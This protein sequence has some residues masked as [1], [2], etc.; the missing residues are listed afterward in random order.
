MQ[1]HG[2][3]MALLSLLNILSSCRRVG[4][5]EIRFEGKESFRHTR[6]QE[7]EN[8]VSV[9]VFFF[10]TPRRGGFSSRNTTK[11]PLF[12]NGFDVKEMFLELG[13]E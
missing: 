10:F 2:A 4:N 13:G 9:S 8:Q 6:R 1:S 12:R 11:I 7:K 5:K 3:K